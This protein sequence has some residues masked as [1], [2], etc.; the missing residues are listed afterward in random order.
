[1]NTFILPND[2]FNKTQVDEAFSHLAR[3]NH[4]LVDQDTLEVQGKSEDKCVYVGW[5]LTPEQYTDMVN[6]NPQIKFLTSPTA[7]KS[8]HYF[9]EWAFILRDVTIPFDE[10][11]AGDKDLQAY[12]LDHHPLFIKTQ[13]KSAGQMSIVRNMEEFYKLLDHMDS[14]EF[15]HETTGLVFRDV[16]D[17]QDELRLFSFKGTVYA[18]EGT[19]TAYIE[20]ARLVTRRL[21]LPF[22]SVDI[23]MIEGKPMVVEVG[24]GGVSGLKH[25]TEEEYFKMFEGKTYV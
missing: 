18:A 20:L 9:Y 7:Y 13:T 23:A 5:M 19:P 25:W 17:V 12:H 21:S 2:Y 16:V 10:T 22:I 3:F 15:D 1:M 4:F 24:D 14:Y 6:K 11:L 8:A